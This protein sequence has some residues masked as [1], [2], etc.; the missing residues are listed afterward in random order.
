MALKISGNKFVF[1]GLLKS[2]VSAIERMNRV[3]LNLLYITE[4]S[5]F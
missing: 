4:R 2:D 5:N 3:H 1:F